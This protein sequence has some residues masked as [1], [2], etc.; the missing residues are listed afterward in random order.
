MVP[1]RPP[2]GVAI[3]ILVDLIKLAGESQDLRLAFLRVLLSDLMCF[4]LVWETISLRH[5]LKG[6]DRTRIFQSIF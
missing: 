1:R 6:H 3:N 2:C 5:E 4:H